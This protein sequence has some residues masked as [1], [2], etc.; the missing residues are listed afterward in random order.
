MTLSFGTFHAHWSNLTCGV[1][2]K[3]TIDANYWN[4]QRVSV[5]FV[6]TESTRIAAVPL[7]LNQQ[8]DNRFRK[9]KTIGGHNCSVLPFGPTG[10]IAPG[11]PG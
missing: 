3:L 1:Q 8:H 4:V 7:I 2:I 6:K 10:P 11:C 9:E 5:S